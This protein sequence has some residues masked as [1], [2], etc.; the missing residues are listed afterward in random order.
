MLS[1]VTLDIFLYFQNEN[2]QVIEKNLI[3]CRSYYFMVIILFIDTCVKYGL[4]ETFPK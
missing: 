2:V 3:W 4:S 1:I